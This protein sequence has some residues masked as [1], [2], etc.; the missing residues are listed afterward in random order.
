MTAA[1]LELF[2]PPLDAAPL[3]I[4]LIAL[5]NALLA[6]LRNLRALSTKK[7]GGPLPTPLPTVHV[8]YHPEH[9]R[10]DAGIY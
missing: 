9:F 3:I 4:K 5:I 7:P 10:S 8:G 1:K 6:L 2:F